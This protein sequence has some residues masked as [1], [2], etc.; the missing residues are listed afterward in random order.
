[1]K[2]LLAFPLL[3]VT[4]LTHAAVVNRATLPQALA[5]PGVV[6]IVGHGDGTWDAYGPSDLAALPAHAKVTVLSAPELKALFDAAEPLLADARDNA[7]AALDSN[8]TYLAIAS[9]TNAQV[10]AQVRA[11]TQQMQRV[12]QALARFVIKAQP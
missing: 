6:A 10:A 8:A 2:L 5:V 9:P 4:S 12:I 7:Q 3:L 1:M 11:L